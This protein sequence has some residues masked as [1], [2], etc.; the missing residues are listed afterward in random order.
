MNP[1]RRN[2][3]EEVQNYIKAMNFA[4]EKLETLPL[5]TRLIKETH[6]VLMQGVRGKH[7]MPGEVRS[8]QN[9]IGGSTIKDA[10]FIPPAHF[11]IQE[12]LSDLEKFLNNESTPV[13]NLIKIA[14]A[15]YQF[16]TIHPFL[17]VNGR[18]GRLIITLFLVRKKLLAKPTLYLSDFFEKNKQLYYDNLN[19]TRIKN[20]I[21]QWLKFFLVG[22]IETS[23]NSVQTFKAIL[24][25]RTK[26]E[27][28]VL[29][30][31]GKRSQKAHQLM[32]YLYKRPIITVSEI[33][34]ILETSI[35]SANKLVSDFEKMG[36]LKEM[37]GY[38]R[39]RIFVFREYIQ[40]FN[41]D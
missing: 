3:W 12:L 28:Q 22:I 6:A 2:D 34:T 11:K 25:L 14:I 24:E 5:S 4:I 39:N 9:W 33:V 10:V 37:T 19:N 32:V 15:H 17:D 20:D 29:I 30:D 1:E 27:H 35:P 13:P 38:K 7:K 8:S 31:F 40:I 36:I 16:E 18:I 41:N 26:Y 23:K 21:E